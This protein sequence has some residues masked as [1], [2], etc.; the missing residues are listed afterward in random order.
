ML[1]LLCRHYQVWIELSRKIVS[2]FPSIAINGK[3]RVC[4]EG[5]GK[6]LKFSLIALIPLA[7]GHVE[8]RTLVGLL[9]PHNKLVTIYHGFKV[10]R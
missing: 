2:N 10:L 7:I 5:G 8:H 3:S 6:V 1:E 9:H 4:F